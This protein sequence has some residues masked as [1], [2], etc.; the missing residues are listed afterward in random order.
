MRSTRAGTGRGVESCERRAVSEILRAWLNEKKHTREVILRV[1]F[2][3]GNREFALQR[4]D[5]CELVR[6]PGNDPNE[7]P[8]SAAEN[9]SSN[10]WRG[11]HHGSGRLDEVTGCE[12]SATESSSQVPQF[13]AALEVRAS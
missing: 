11:E 3:V 7:M 9:Y 4:I 13:S 1:E 12:P 5:N 6:V 10:R 8:C 2:R